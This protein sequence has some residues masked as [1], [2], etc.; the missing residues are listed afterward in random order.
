M[1]AG[2]IPW[3][4][5][6]SSRGLPPPPAN[7]T[8]TTCGGEYGWWFQGEPCPAPQ[9]DPVWALNLSTIPHTPWGDDISWSST[10]FYDAVNASQW[11]MVSAT[12]DGMTECGEC[13]ARS[14]LHMQCMVLLPQCHHSWTHSSGTRLT[15]DSIDPLDPPPPPQVNFDWADGSG[16]WQDTHPHNNEAIL[17]E[18]CKRVKAQGT[19]TKC[20]VYRNTELALQWQETSRAA[21]T[22]ENVD[23]NWFLKF[24]TR[25]AC[26]AAVPCNIAA[27]HNG[28]DPT[29][30]PCNKTA[31]ISAPNCAYCCNFTAGGTSGAYNEPIG[32]RILSP[33]HTQNLFGDNA[34]GD[35][36]LFWDFRNQE[37]QD[38]WAQEVVLAGTDSPYVDGMFTDDPPGYGSEHPIVQSVVQLTKAEIVALQ[39][40]TQRAWTQALALVTRAKKYIAQAFQIPPVFDAGVQSNVSACAAWMRQQCAVRTNESALAYLGPGSTTDATPNMS[41]AAYLVVRGP[42]SFIQAPS[43]VIQGRDWTDPAYRVYRLDTGTPTGPC[44]ESPTGVFTRGWSG[45]HASIDCGTTSATLDF[46]LL[47]R[48]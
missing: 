32:G 37:V 45:G 36:Q 19:G 6:V 35:G 9:W 1:L 2:L 26:D 41:M 3:L 17:V 15:S 46:K 38:Y 48:T 8:R 30:V 44:V 34:L 33:G 20:F 21:M 47:P 24:K 43:A 27:F 42:Y 40:G 31:P 11:G 23:K 18:Q 7:E 12:S 10:G 13:M 4:A 25:A 28:N 16:I 14:S 22:Q 29:S 5:C 39:V